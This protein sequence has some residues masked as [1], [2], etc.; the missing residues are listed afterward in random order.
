MKASSK[1]STIIL[2]LCEVIIG[3][4][5]LV[6]PVGF[7]TGIIVFLGIVLLIL[8]I[9]NIVQYFRTPPEIA[10]VKRSLSRGC[11]EILL[12]FFCV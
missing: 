3:V 9:T 11:L 4:L 5:L 10:V 12:G 8:G 2:S 7:T 6:D 1:A